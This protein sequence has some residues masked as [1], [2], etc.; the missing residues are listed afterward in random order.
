VSGAP[1][2]RSGHGLRP[3]EKLALGLE[4]F[5]A[6]NAMPV[7]FLLALR[8]DG[9]L[10]GLPPSLLADTPFPDF[11]VPGILLALVVGGAALAAAAALLARRPAASRLVLCSGVLLMGWITVQVALLG[12]ESVLQPAMFAL[13]AVLASL[14]RPLRRNALERPTTAGRGT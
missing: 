7:G 3:A 11:R 13:G 12:Y 4:A 6:V 9:S 1:I 14:S 8:P 2:A 5:L 10:V